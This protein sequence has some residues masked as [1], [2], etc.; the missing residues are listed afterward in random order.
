MRSK[1]EDA[2]LAVQRYLRGPSGGEE[3]ADREAVRY[4]TFVWT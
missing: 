2:L 1:L 4:F 3:M